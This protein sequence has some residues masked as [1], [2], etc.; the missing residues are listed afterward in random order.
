MEK[1][2]VEQVRELFARLA[3]AMEDNKELLTK[4]DAESGDG[5]LGLTMSMGF[6]KI[7]EKISAVTETDIGKLIAVAGSTMAQAVPSTMGTLMGSAL[8]RGGKALLGKTELELPD[9]AAMLSAM[10]EGI[11]ARGK[12]KPGDKTVLD[13]L[14]PAAIALRDAVESGKSFSVGLEAAAAAAVQG[15]EDTKT[16][17]PQHGR[18]AYYAEK[19]LGRQDPGATVGMIFVK[20]LAASSV[21][22]NQ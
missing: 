3:Q 10:V 22:K 20:V 15:L 21:T 17:V 16:M 5:D 11:M 1:W 12:A 19:A 18:A 9:I 8:M 4:L 14:D 7:T 13:S 6:Q 2:T